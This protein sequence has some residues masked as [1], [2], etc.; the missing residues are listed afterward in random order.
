MS[1]VYE[2]IV[3]SVFSGVLAS[4]LIFLIVYTFKNSI[5]PWLRQI[6]YRGIDI[7]GSWYW[8][9]ITNDSAKLELTQY[10]DKV[11]GIYTYVNNNNGNI[12]I[13]TVS[14]NI[15]D[16]FIQ[17]SMKSADKKRLGVLSYISE[18]VGDGNELKGYSTFYATNLHRLCTEEESLFRSEELVQEH[19]K[20]LS[21]DN[22]SLNK[23]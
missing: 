5:I 11:K 8:T 2:N 19:L 1:T 17:L 3:I 20:K 21:K 4:T 15:Q 14:G 10:A 13:Y 6:T 7:S 22:K 9:N 23:N 18:V 16:R 12:K